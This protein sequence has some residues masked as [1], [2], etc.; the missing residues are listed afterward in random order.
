M[1]PA[2]RS[3]S[4]SASMIATRSGAKLLLFCTIGLLAW[5]TWSRW[6][7]MFGSMLGM[8]DGDHALLFWRKMP[9]GC[10]SLAMAW[11]LL[12]C[13]IPPPGMR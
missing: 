4:I 8:S 5:L 7:M 9:L 13:P 1:K 2:A 3:L 10:A 6:Q 12:I 11:S